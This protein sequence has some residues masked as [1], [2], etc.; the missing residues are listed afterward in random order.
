[1]ETERFETFDVTIA[2][3]EVSA[4]ANAAM[5]RGE[6]ELCVFSFQAIVFGLLQLR[7][8]PAQLVAA[9]NIGPEERAPFDCATVVSR[10]MR[11]RFACDLFIAG[12]SKGSQIAQVDSHVQQT[13]T[14]NNKVGRKWE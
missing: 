13:K 6:L 10:T 7:F 4:Q 14:N 9:P 1:M 8:Q 12:I 5:V 2:F 3:G 11:L